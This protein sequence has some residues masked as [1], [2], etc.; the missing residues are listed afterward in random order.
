MGDRID[1]Q[2]DVIARVAVA[3]LRSALSRQRELRKS[4]GPA[5]PRLAPLL[6]VAFTII[7]EL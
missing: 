5:P 2:A 6:G 7:S 3:A 4:G 1:F